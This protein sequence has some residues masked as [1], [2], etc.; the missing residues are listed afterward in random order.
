MSSA[1]VAMGRATSD[2]TPCVAPRR[3]ASIWRSGVIESVLTTR[4]SS[5][6][7]ARAAP[8][9]GGS[10]TPMA[11]P[12]DIACTIGI[13]RTTVFTT[14]CV[15]PLTIASTGS[16]SRWATSII[17]P[18]QPVSRLQ[19]APSCSTTTTRSAPR[20]RSDFACAFTVATGSSNR[21]P[22][23][24]DAFVVLGVSVVAM[25]T[26]PIFPPPRSTIVSPRIHGTPLPSV[27]F[28]TFAASIA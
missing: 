17:S 28:R 20:A 8:S 19:N 25:P 15:W 3:S 12:D 4:T 27:A 14:E 5:R 21:S 23:T 1:T 9:T 26:I 16:V 22:A 24:F 10:I 18:R 7:F 2:A 6:V 11:R 13:P